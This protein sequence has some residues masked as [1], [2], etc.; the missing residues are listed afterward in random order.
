[1][2]PLDDARR[3]AWRWSARTAWGRRALHDRAFR[4]EVLAHGHLLAAFLLT[5]VAPM[6]M[7]LLGP[8]LLGV[9]HVASDL[10]YFVLRPPYALRRRLLFLAPLFAMV[11]VRSWA[12][13]VGP[14]A[15]TWEV[16]LGFSSCIALVWLVPLS[17]TRRVVTS[18]VLVTIWGAVH[19]RAWTFL[20]VFAHA[21]NGVALALWLAL[22][23][24]VAPKARIVRIAAAW[25]VCMAMLMSG[26]VDRAWADVPAIGA[27]RLETLEASLAP[28]VP[29][30]WSIRTVM[31]FGFAQSVHYAIWLRL[32]PQTLDPRPAPSTFARG[33]E[34]LTVDWGRA[35][36]VALALCAV[37]FPM[38]ALVWN[39]E[40]ARISYLVAVVFHGWLEI[41]AAVVWLAGGWTLTRS[42]RSA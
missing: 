27:F 23:S 25:L 5:L 42:G 24:K 35:G 36:V 17:T 16:A 2:Q 33:M 10:R 39:A 31:A 41:A 40:G 22:F 30:P 18:L 4:I 9:P 15:P 38:L 11:A 37:A 19:A 28:D 1:M 34:R 8:L 3:L 14:W 7:M 29:W 12:W 32:V 20:L 13:L 21:H 26:L 6:W